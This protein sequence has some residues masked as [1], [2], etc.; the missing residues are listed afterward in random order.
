[1]SIGKFLKNTELG[2]DDFPCWISSFSFID[3]LGISEFL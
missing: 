2:C 3:M 1:M